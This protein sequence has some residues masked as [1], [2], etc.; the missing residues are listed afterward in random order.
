ME[1]WQT[2]SSRFSVV[3]K[4]RG[5]TAYDEN[6]GMNYDSV[7]QGE[8]EEVSNAAII[9]YLETGTYDLEAIKEQLKK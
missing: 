7:L 8:S 1:Q 9:S 3:L 2:E 5:N 4:E 6:L